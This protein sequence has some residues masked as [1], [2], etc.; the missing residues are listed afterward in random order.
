MTR[1]PTW[2]AVSAVALVAVLAAVYGL[3]AS[4]DGPGGQAG[5]GA[6]AFAQ[7]EVRPLRL[8]EQD[9]DGRCP[10]VNAIQLPGVPTEG[11][12]GPGRPTTAGLRRLRRGPIYVAVPG[13]PRFLRWPPGGSAAHDRAWRSAEVLWLSK[14]S[15]D[16]PVLVRGGQLDGSRRLRF[17]PPPRLKL[18]LPGKAWMEQRNP[19]RVWGRRRRALTHWG[20]TQVP[21]HAAARAGGFGLG[22]KTAIWGR[23]HRNRPVS[24]RIAETASAGADRGQSGL[25][26]GIGLRRAKSRALHGKEGVRGSSPRVGSR[27]PLHFA[28]FS[29]WSSV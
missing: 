12:L 3:A 15:Y 14:P 16:G 22:P 27:K 5:S 26:S 10:Q 23:N 21:F 11:G 17:S 8:P 20:A 7:L 13:A 24:S 2:V 6:D 25:D 18:R 1:K 29:V 9:A 19:L 28:S 4:G